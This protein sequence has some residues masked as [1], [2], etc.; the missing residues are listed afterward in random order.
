LKEHGGAEEL[1]VAHGQE[2]LKK[3]IERLGL[4]IYLIQLTHKRK[5]LKKRIESD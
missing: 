1:R 5:N 4:H 2:N 3:R